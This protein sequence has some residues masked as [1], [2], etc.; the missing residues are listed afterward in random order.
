MLL[1][2]ILQAKGNAVYT[3]TPDAMLSQV[4]ASLVDHNCGSLVV[5]EGEQMVGIITERDILRALSRGNH[6]E[7]RPVQEVMTTEVITGRPDLPVED[8]MGLMTENRIRHLPVL[9]EGRLAGMISI[10]DVVK[11][12]HD[13]LTTENHYLKSYISGDSGV[14]AK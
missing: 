8:T 2:E 5:C 7:T 4:V 10:G 6:M 11:A 9:E 14:I 1:H 13:A 3:T 12:Q